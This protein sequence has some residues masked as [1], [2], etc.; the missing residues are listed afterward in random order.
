ML[1]GVLASDMPTTSTRGGSWGY[2]ASPEMRA[3]KEAEKVARAS[4][5]TEQAAAKR[6][7]K[8]MRNLSSRGLGQ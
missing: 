3:K 8:R 4:R 1:A 6:E 2:P 5:L 7:R